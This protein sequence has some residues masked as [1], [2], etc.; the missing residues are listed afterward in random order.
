[1]GPAQLSEASSIMSKKVGPG[2]KLLE[3]ASQ[4]QLL[5]VLHRSSDAI[6]LC[7]M[8]YLKMGVPIDCAKIK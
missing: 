8:V 6:P 4:F 1:M 7:L 3:Y 5:A 2:S